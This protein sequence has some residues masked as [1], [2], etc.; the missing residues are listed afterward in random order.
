[1]LKTAENECRKT[2]ST[3][4]RVDGIGAGLTQG[5]SFVATLG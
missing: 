1:M 2:D 3:L 5:G 4:C